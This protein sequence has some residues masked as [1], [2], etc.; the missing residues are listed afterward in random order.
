MFARNLTFA[1]ISQP[2]PPSSPTT[3]E[4]YAVVHQVL[5]IYTTNNSPM[6]RLI[7]TSWAVTYPVTGNKL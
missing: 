1:L 6:F 3:I 7:V 2:I 4:H 5:R